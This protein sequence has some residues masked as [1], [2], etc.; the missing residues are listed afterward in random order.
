MKTKVSLRKTPKP[1]KKRIKIAILI[2]SY[3]LLRAYNLF[4]L[5]TNKNYA[6]ITK[7]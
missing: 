1:K 3:D 6:K 4:L 2:T 5:L 7:F